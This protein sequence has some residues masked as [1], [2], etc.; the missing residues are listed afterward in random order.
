M[1]VSSET[2]GEDSWLRVE[3]ADLE[4]LKDVVPD[5][6]VGEARVQL[7]EVGVVHILKHDRRR[8]RLGASRKAEGTW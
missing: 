6:E 4:E 5:V 7:L 2:Q 3:R 8:F 1:S